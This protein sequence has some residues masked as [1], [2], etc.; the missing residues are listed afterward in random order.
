MT[1]EFNSDEFKKKVL[2][3]AIQ[4]LRKGADI[5][6]KDSKER[7]P[8]KT[9]ALRASIKVYANDYTSLRIGSHIDYAFLQHEANPNGKAFFL[10][11]A[12]YDD[13][14][15]VSDIV[16]EEIENRLKR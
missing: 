15:I 9:G 3:G 13:I 14:D 6:V 12:L 11:N 7:C 8:V 1:I 16:C 10:R 5:V 4:G 2:D